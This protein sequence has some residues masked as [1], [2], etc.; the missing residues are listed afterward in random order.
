MF[1][2]LDSSLPVRTRSDAV[3]LL[4][5]LAL[6]VALSTFALSILGCSPAVTAGPVEDAVTDDAPTEAER[7]ESSDLLRY[8]ASVTPA[9]EEMVVAQGNIKETLGSSEGDLSVGTADREAIDNE[10]ARIRA[11]RA[12]LEDIDPPASVADVHAD[13]VKGAAD[14]DDGLTTFTLGI[15]TGDQSKIDEAGV[16][17]GQGN[18]MLNES[19]ARM[20]EAVAAEQ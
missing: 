11:L 12:T 14:I 16:L 3:S 2:P 9:T 15:D 7:R 10:I 13:I 20:L 18:D 5:R 4:L 1:R 17:I 6:I 8:A 19:V